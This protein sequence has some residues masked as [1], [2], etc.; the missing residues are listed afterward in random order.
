MIDKE[1]EAS[2]NAFLPENAFQKDQ[3]VDFLKSDAS[4]AKLF[5][6]E[7]RVALIAI[8]ERILDIHYYHADD[9]EKPHQEQIF[10]KI[11]NVEAK[12]RNHRH[13][14]GKTFSAKAEF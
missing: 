7:Q 10:V 8:V 2:I 13:E 12:L 5:T 3:I 9:E 14:T 1:F 4:I 11:D 6:K